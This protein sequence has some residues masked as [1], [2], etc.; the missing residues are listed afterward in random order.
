M[1]QIQRNLKSTITK[2][3]NVAAGSRLSDRMERLS[4]PTKIH[5]KGL[6]NRLQKAEAIHKK[7]KKEEALAR[8][9]AAAAAAVKPNRNK[10]KSTP[11]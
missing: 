2:K 11:R 1:N 9:A 4:R 8:V 7:E 10:A 6:I 5:E 3:S